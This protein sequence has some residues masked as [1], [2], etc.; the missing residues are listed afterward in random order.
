MKHP[1]VIEHEAYLQSIERLAAPRKKRPYRDNEET[2]LG[3]RLRTTAIIAVAAFVL[4]V[5]AGA[6]FAA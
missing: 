2:D 6:P 5:L 3:L 1:N 4:L